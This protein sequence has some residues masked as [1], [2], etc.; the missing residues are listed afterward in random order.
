MFKAFIQTPITQIFYLLKLYWC[1]Q[2]CAPMV[3]QDAPRLP[4]SP[5]LTAKSS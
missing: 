2:L 3:S 4:N 1:A 5:V